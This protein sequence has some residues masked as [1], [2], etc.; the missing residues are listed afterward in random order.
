MTTD[1]ARKAVFNTPELLEKIISLVSPR[2]ILTKA[3]RLS[4][5]WKDAVDCSPIIKI[6]LWMRVPNV[7]AIQPTAFTNMHTFPEMPFVGRLGMPLSSHDVAFNPLPLASTGETF[8]LSFISLHG[9]SGSWRLMVVT[10]THRRSSSHIQR[11]VADSIVQAL[12]F[13]AAGG[14]CV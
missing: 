11:P 12:G 10:C 2:D 5:Q 8:K 6:Q 3:Q 9:L 7:T 14:T 13:E 4:R 1:A